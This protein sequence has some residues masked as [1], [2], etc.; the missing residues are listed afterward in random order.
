MKY[1]INFYTSL[2]SIHLFKKNLRLFLVVLILSLSMNIFHLYFNVGNLSVIQGI[3]AS[4]SYII[5]LPILIRKNIVFGKEIT[6]LLNVIMLI[7][8]LIFIIDFSFDIINI[9]LYFYYNDLDYVILPNTPTFLGYIVEMTQKYFFTETECTKKFT[10][11][12]AMEGRNPSEPTEPLIDKKN[13]EGSQSLLKFL[14]MVWY[15]QLLLLV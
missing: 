10:L 15:Y 14:Q 7:V 11:K 3:L 4:L 1:L 13:G 5:I 9:S 6:C 2:T 8:C 12:E